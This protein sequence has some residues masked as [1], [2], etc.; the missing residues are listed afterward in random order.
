MQAIVRGELVGAYEQE[1][2]N[3]GKVRY[4]IVGDRDN[5]EKMRFFLDKDCK[6][7]G[8]QKGQV[9]EL[10]LNLEQVGYKTYITCKEIV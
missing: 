8:Q 2:K 4:V 6:L 1:T 7:N 5:Y 10:K 3:G 9:V